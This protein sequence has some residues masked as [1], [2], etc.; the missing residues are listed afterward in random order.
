MKTFLRNG[1]QSS[2][3]YIVNFHIRVPIYCDILTSSMK[4]FI[5]DYEHRE[6]EAEEMEFSIMFYIHERVILMEKYC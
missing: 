2:R 3:W 1:K 6:E 4:F 5:R